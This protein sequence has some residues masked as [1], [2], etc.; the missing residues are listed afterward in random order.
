MGETLRD[1]YAISLPDMIRMVLKLPRSLL[2]AIA[3]LAEWVLRWVGA[4]HDIRS[5]CHTD[6][7]LYDKAHTTRLV[8]TRLQSLTITPNT[9]SPT[10]PDNAPLAATA[11]YPSER[12]K[13]EAA[14][15]VWS[16]QLVLVQYDHR[17]ERT[18]VMQAPRSRARVVA[19]SRCSVASRRYGMICS[20]SRRQ[21]SRDPSVVR[22]VVVGEIRS[23]YA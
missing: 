12:T 15:H 16:W 14:F 20:S 18:V 17:G 10:A 23:V 19:R 3:G 7:W 11:L 8:R 9:S 21:R 13:A 2:Y 5:R 22:G 4:R 6:L 1:R